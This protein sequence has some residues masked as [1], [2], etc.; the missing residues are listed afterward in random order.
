MQNRSYDVNC[1]I[2]KVMDQN[3]IKRKTL[4]IYCFLVKP[5]KLFEQL[6]NI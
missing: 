5:K 3:N 4:Y 1:R 6:N 2:K